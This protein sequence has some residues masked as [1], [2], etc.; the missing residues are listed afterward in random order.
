MPSPRNSSPA[1]SLRVSASFLNERSAMAN[2]HGS[3]PKPSR[4]RYAARTSA[5]RE[6]LE[7]RCVRVEHWKRSGDEALHDLVFGA[8]IFGEVEIGFPVSLGL[9]VEIDGVEL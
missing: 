9:R 4:T 8:G 1:P 2:Y 5:P 7:I 6:L 3:P